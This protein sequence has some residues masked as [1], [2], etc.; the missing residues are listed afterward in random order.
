MI[1]CGE[2]DIVGYQLKLKLMW[3]L[4][5]T[6]RC[7][8]TIQEV[9][10]R[11]CSVH[12]YLVCLCGVAWTVWVHSGA[13]PGERDWVMGSWLGDR[14]SWK[15]DSR[16]FLQTG[17][18]PVLLSDIWHFLSTAA[19]VVLC[20][21]RTTCRSLPKTVNRHPWISSGTKRYSD[22]GQTLQKDLRKSMV[23]NSRR[24]VRARRSTSTA[25]SP[26]QTHHW[27]SWH[28]LCCL[29]FQCFSFGSQ[30]F[31]SRILQTTM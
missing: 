27:P 17:V 8:T 6:L 5:T 29:L 3:P 23:L 21:R 31:D 18:P 26:A 13:G 15:R 14:V 30:S 25:R 24:Y 19:D 4:P 28:L 9:P 20:T 10:S 7:T 11:E 2:I 1:L 16:P 12:F 22:E